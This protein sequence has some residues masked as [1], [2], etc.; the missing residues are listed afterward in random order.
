MHT[1]SLYNDCIVG[2]DYVD[3]K[4]NDTTL[5]RERNLPKFPSSME[6]TF[7]V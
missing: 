1:Y 6:L 7:L 2:S 3:I 4:L 5:R